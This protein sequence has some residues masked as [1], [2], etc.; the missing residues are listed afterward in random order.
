MDGRQRER[1]LRRRF[2]APLTILLLLTTV[3]PFVYVVWLSLTDTSPLLRHSGFVGLSNFGTLITS[4]SVWSA[5]LVTIEFAVGSIILSV[6]IGAIVAV[7][8]SRVRKGRTVI[9]SILIV[10]LALA[11]VAVM[12]DWQIMLNPTLGVTNYILN[13][14]G[15]PQPDWLATGHLALVTLVMIEVWEWTPL[16]IILVAGGLAALPRSVLE[17]AATD[18]ATALK[19]FWYVTAPLL[20]PQLVLAV[21]FTGIVA[22]GNLTSVVILTSGGP[23]GATTS[24]AYLAYT[25]SFEDLRFGFGAAVAVISIVVVLVLARILL[26]ALKEVEGG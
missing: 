3:L 25:Q 14:V 9:R 13:L 22:L 12:Y 18:G 1:Q 17:A 11:P 4:G 6:G 8:L 19:T 5:V 21:L 24:I 15:L 20:K 2:L 7:A 16:S 23:G 26:M 10:P